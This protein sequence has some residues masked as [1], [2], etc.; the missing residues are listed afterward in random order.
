MDNSRVVFFV[1]DS[2]KRKIGNGQTISGI[3]TQSSEPWNDGV[4]GNLEILLDPF[5]QHTYDFE[6]KCRKDTKRDDMR[7]ELIP[8]LTQKISKT[9]MSRSWDVKE[10]PHH[11]EFSRKIGDVILLDGKYQL[12]TGYGIYSNQMWTERYYEDGIRLGASDYAMVEKSQ[13]ILDSEIVEKVINSYVEVVTR[14]FNKY[15]IKFISKNIL[16]IH[17]S[18]FIDIKAW[19]GNAK[20]K[21]VLMA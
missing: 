15:H 12:V 11:L 13:L 6:N 18:Q 4:Y 21:I 14:N 1:G 10:I 17:L 3:V 2:V 19:A 5:M 7:V 20:Q 16:D 9:Y 8:E